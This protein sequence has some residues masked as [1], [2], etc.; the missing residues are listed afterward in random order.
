VVDWIGGEESLL[1]DLTYPWSEIAFADGQF[2]LRPSP[3]PHAEDT[4]PEGYDPADHPVKMVTFEGSAA[5]CDWLN[6]RAGLPLT[7]DHASWRC[8]EEG[9]YAAVGYR[10]P[11][12]AEW[13]RAAR[14]PDGRLRPWGDEL[15]DCERANWRR[16]CWGWTTPAGH[17]PGAPEVAGHRFHDLIGNLW[18]WVHDWWEE[19]PDTL[20]RVD[21]CGPPVAEFRSLRGGA[22]W[23]FGQDL[24]CALRPSFIPDYMGGHVGFRI[25]RTAPPRSGPPPGTSESPEQTWR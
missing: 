16:E 14:F 13:E 1:V 3:S 11:T 21:P 15:C 5:F 10:L 12:D 22:W 18:E 25:A 2:S 8:R 6:L 17:Y 20:L 23:T 24:R 9:P 19:I 4:Y 7:Y